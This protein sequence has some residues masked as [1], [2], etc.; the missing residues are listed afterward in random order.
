MNILDLPENIFLNL[1]PYLEDNEVYLTL[2]SVCK[3]LRI[4]C[5][6]YI[7]LEAK[8]HLIREEY[9]FCA[10]FW[11][12]YFFRK[13]QRMEPFYFKSTIPVTGWKS[14]IGIKHDYFTR[15]FNRGEYYTSFGTEHNG[16]I[17]AGSYS[18]SRSRHKEFTKQYF[19]YE[20]TQKTKEWNQLP[21]TNKEIKCAPKGVI[22]AKCTVGN[23]DLV[24]FDTGLH[25]LEL[26][27]KTIART[28]FNFISSLFQNVKRDEYYPTI[29]V[30]I[31]RYIQTGKLFNCFEFA[32]VVSLTKDKFILVAPNSSIIHNEYNVV[33]DKFQRYNKEYF[34]STPKMKIWEGLVLENKSCVRWS[35]IEMNQDDNDSRHLRIRPICFKIKNN[36]YIVSSLV[37]G[38]YSEDEY[39]NS[40]FCKDYTIYAKDHEGYKAHSTCDRYDIIEKKYYSTDYHYPF[41]A[42]PIHLCGSLSLIHI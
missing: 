40:R 37:C 9:P 10:S 15:G 14:E 42:Y 21:S 38:E 17:I 33:D 28:T 39:L 12:L 5:E 23:S 34:K 1:F 36:L 8:F 13:N 27:E 2:R 30:R 3:R 41:G 35:E 31:L 16:K 7:K 11:V 25:I 29:N 32:S 6:S 22:L 24:F 20:Y 26:P 18:L 19:F 4:Y